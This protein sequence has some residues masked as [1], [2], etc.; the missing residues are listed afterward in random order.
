MKQEFVCGISGKPFAPGDHVLIQEIKPEAEGQLPYTR[1]VKAE[2][3][4]DEDGI[5]AG[6]ENGTVKVFDIE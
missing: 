2:L 5:K 3:V 6:L 4:L 1:F